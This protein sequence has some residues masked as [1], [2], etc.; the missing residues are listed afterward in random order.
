MNSLRTK[1]FILWVIIF[2]LCWHY[3]FSQETTGNQ[4]YITY[5]DS[6]F[7]SKLPVK[8]SDQPLRSWELP[9]YVNNSKNK[10]FRSILS[11]EGAECGQLA[12]VSYAF[13]YEINRLRDL[14]SNLPEN[15]YPSHFTY[16]FM[17]GGNGWSGVSFHHS[18]EILKK[19]GC[20]NVVDFGG[21]NCDPSKWISG[22]DKYY[23]GM[24]NRLKDVYQ[25]KVD[26][27]QDLE[28]LKEWLFNH[29]ENST[30]GGLATFYAC[31]P[32]NLRVLPD[33]TPEAGKYV[34]TDWGGIP[35]HSM[36]IVG[37]NDSIR[38][39]YNQDGEYTNDIDI[40]G[41]NIVDLR[42][43][44]MGGLIFADGYF[45]GVNFADSGF[46]YMMY[47]TIANTDE[48]YGIWNNAVFIIEPFENYQS[49]LSARIK[50]NHNSREQI[51]ISAGISNNGDA[52]IPD[53]VLSFPIFNFQGGAQYMQGGLSPDS[54]KIIEFGLDISP[55]LNY[56]QPGEEAA[57]FLQVEE[58]DP[59]S[60]GFGELMEYSLLDH[61][62]QNVISCN[63]V[64]PSAIPNNTISWYRIN[65]K[66]D[67]FNKLLITENKIPEAIVNE[68]YYYQMNATGGV[69]PY[70]WSLRYP[71]VSDAGPAP[72]PSVNS[73]EITPANETKGIAEVP[74]DFDFP[75]YGNKYDTI[76]VHTDGFLTFKYSQLPYPYMADE[77][78]MIS[79]SKCISP[80]LSV[81]F[82]TLTEEGQGIW[83]DKDSSQL[84]V[85]W[86]A[87]ST[88]P[89][90]DSIEFACNINKNGIIT[91]FY[92]KEHIAHDYLWSYGISDGD[93]FNYSTAYLHNLNNFSSDYSISF[94][95][96][97]HP[98][99]IKISNDGNLYG[100]VPGK[101]DSLYLEVIVKD[102]KNNFDMR[103]YKFHSSYL[104]EEEL[105]Y[106]T[107]SIEIKT[108]PNPFSNS[109]N[110]SYT[111]IGKDLVRIYISDIN[112]NF[113][114]ELYSGLAHFKDLRLAWDGRNNSGRMCDPGVYILCL[115]LSDNIRTS[116]IIKIH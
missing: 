19:V 18:Y 115:R 63:T 110:I 92:N 68:P 101:Y 99:E 106:N 15:Q 28:V 16:N 9:G 25:I 57:F 48:E 21:V 69:A 45:D 30:V 22:Y 81:F 4:K 38:Y 108:Y 24:K 10:Y 32:W 85:R 8:K 61:I 113:I 77:Q 59:L 1:Y 109:L 76:Y 31:S 91:F 36:V 27:Q 49:I 71:Y 96:A 95:P 107:D 58:K 97:D 44:E 40:N 79:S 39:D 98:E 53:H 54:N 94:T 111:G 86:L 55:L 23:N 51:S 78:L 67:D 43:C 13:A 83:I 14:N 80:L 74:L 84:T 11:Q 47:K 66:I 3:S 17:N 41:D 102:D 114:K 88:F 90:L 52:A 93:G 20:M 7:L 2:N 100:T 34:I 105:S 62:N 73:Q 50:L 37:Y 82:Q 116:K 64:L 35:S 75:F 112:G 42:D 87:S 33:S 12:S 6:I 72:F 104:F 5:N 60:M 70:T 89:M 46:C 103:S 65:Y 56:I 29:H 26:T